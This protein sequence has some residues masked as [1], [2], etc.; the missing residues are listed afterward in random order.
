MEIYNKVQATIQG[1][2][3]AHRYAEQRGKV[4]KNAEK[5]EDG[6]ED[7]WTGK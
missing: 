4:K 1:K 3:K 7:V 5:R 6:T 2:T